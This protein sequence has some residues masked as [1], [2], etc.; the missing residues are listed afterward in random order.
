MNEVIDLIK[1]NVLKL[2]VTEGELK[3]LEIINNNPDCVR[4][5]IQDELNIGPEMMCYFKKG[6]I[7]KKLIIENDRIFKINDNGKKVIELSKQVEI[8]KRKPKNSNQDKV[9]VVE[10]TETIS[11]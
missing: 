6:L 2:N 5:L 9:E 1:N 10:Q 7:N 11:P 3:I 8:K 4:K